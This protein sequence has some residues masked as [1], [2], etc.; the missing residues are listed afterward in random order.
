MDEM[1]RVQGISRQKGQKED[2]EIACQQQIRQ[3]K[4]STRCSNEMKQTI[5]GM[6]VLREVEGIELLKGSILNHSL[7]LIRHSVQDV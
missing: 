4:Q 3:Q 2:A 1:R 5:G 7:T 6:D